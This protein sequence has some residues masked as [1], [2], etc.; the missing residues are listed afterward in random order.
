MNF[1]FTHILDQSTNQ[2]E[3]FDIVAKPVAL[4]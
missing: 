1:T 2:G 3:V 4:K